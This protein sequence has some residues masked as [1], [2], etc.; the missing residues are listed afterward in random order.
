MII[1]AFAHLYPPAYVEFVTK[2]NRPL[3]V[4]FQDTPLFTS[5][6]AR[7]EEMDRQDIDMQ[8]LTVGTP[9][10]DE[11]FGPDQIAQAQE[12]ARIANDGLAAVVATHPDR[13]IGVATLPLVSLDAVDTALAE[14]DRATTQLDLK[15]VQL[16]T[17]VASSPI[18]LPEMFPIY[19]YLVAADIPILLHPV[20]G[21]YNRRTQDYLLWLTF[22]WPFET[23]L[24][25]ARLVYSG[26][27]ERYPNLKIL[28][29]HLGA[30]PPYMA[31][32]IKG[33]TTTLERF[34]DWELPQPILS[35]FKRFYGDTAVNGYKPALT[36]GL[37]FF[38]A[39]HILFATDFPFVPVDQT[40]RSILDW[41]IGEPEKDQILG[42]NARRLFKHEPT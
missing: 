7:I 33:V 14:L 3:P 23:S 42:E 25:M 28:T 12:A 8:V 27:M 35:Y 11:L 37:E 9:A 40:L 21:N 32:R 20:G 19:D 29:H 15:G 4:F 1:D 10:F 31:E 24:A 16:Y 22:G 6:A 38:G 34:T 13:F 26:V 36:T 18:D 39:D 2:L 5:A 30:F 17:D 41:D